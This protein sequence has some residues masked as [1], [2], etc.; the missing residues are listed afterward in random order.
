MA[1]KDQCK[2]AV[3]Q[4]LGK[5]SLTAQEAANIEARINETMRNMA[6]RDVQKW[7]NLS[8]AERL[9][10]A[11]KQVA[12][13]IQEQ[14]ARKLKIAANDITTQSRNL[15][16]LE[17]PRLPASEV[18]DRLIVAHGDMSGIKSI[19]SYAKGIRTIYEG[20]LTDFY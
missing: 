8:D 16:I 1:M 5:Q 4:A 2:Q 6:R 14:L 18:I 9:T 19:N 12:I 10:E 20:Q 11:S 3:A 13:D 17:H 7:R 15:A